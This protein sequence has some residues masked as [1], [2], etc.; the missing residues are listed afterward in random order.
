MF[1]ETVWSGYNLIKESNICSINWLC[2]DQDVFVKPIF[3]LLS[4]NTDKGPLS[5]GQTVLNINH[6]MQSSELKHGHIA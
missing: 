4:G 2:M 5:P 1:Q 6:G 3:A